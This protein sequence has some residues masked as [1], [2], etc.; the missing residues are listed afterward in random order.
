[1]PPTTTK[2]LTAIGAFTIAFALLLIPSQAYASGAV[3]LIDETVPCPSPAARREQIVG[4]LGFAAGVYAIGL[5]CSLI[6]PD[7]PGASD[8]RIPVVGPWMSLAH[9]GC[10]SH[11]PDCSQGM[12]WTRAIL[13]F[14]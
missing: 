13:T 14:M 4:G 9:T 10:P 5:S 7:A 1:M 12:V 3:C 11:N 8:L 2:R 6:W